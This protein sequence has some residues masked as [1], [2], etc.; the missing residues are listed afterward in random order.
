M[1]ILL[2]STPFS[3]ENCFSFVIFRKTTGSPSSKYERLYCVSCYATVEN[4][5][6]CMEITHRVIKLKNER[7]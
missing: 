7:E 1:D 2:V 4:I 5:R 6:I 3:S